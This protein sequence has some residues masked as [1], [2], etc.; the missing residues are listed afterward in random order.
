MNIE[1]HRITIRGLVE[2]YKDDDEDVS[3][4]TPT[5]IVVTTTP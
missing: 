4:L 3:G 2:G 1:Q 5:E